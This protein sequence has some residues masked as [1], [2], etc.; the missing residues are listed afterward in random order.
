MIM[1]ELLNIIF[2]E[3]FEHRCITYIVYS[4]LELFTTNFTTKLYVYLKM[5]IYSMKK[6]EIYL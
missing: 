1:E 4:I 6:N 2:N 5:K 3:L